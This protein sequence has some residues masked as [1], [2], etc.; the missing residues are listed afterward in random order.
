MIS[1][2]GPRWGLKTV[3]ESLA[4]DNPKTKSAD[5]QFFTDP[6]LLKSVEDSAFIRGLLRITRVLMSVVLK[7]S[8]ALVFRRSIDAPLWRPLL[9]LFRN[10]FK[11]KREIALAVAL[12]FLSA[13]V[14][15]LSM[16]SKDGQKL[17]GRYRFAAEDTGLI[18]VTGPSGELLNGRFVRVGRTTFVASYEKTFGRGSI[19][20]YEPEL[21]D[22]NPFS[23][24]FGS[25]S[26]LPDSAY[27]ES[28]NNTRGKS[29]MMVRGP[30]FYWTASLLG[31]QGTTMGCYLIG[32]SYTGHG[33]GKCKTDAGHE[34]SVEF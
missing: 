3:L 24:V 26:A 13:C 9:A 6:S 12:L 30:L 15:N 27:G 28:F 17:S 7:E 4:K 32:S 10:C 14:H 18:Q 8:C 34:Y 25:S 11:M 19:A 5:A 33:F 2:T 16:H 23:G 1:I 20:V 31:D 21:S 22:V 29:E